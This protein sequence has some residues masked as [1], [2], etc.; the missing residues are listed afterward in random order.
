MTSANPWTEMTSAAE[1]PVAA[2]ALR[3]IHLEGRRCSPRQMA[4]T[5][6]LSRPPAV[7]AT[8]GIGMGRNDAPVL[9][10]SK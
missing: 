8:D 4:L 1:S 7:A 2:S 9:A 5:G 10:P 6:G 3:R